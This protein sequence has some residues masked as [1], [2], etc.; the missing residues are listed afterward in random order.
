MQL[1]SDQLTESKPVYPLDLSSLRAAVQALA[2]AVD[3]VSSP[4]FSAVDLRWRDTLVAGVVQHFEST[5]ELCW[6]MLKR[7]LERELPSPTE[8][9]GSSYRDLFRLGHQRGLVTSVEPW[10]EFRELR[11]ITADT[12]ALDKAKKVASGAPALL[13]EAR[14]LLSIIEVRNRA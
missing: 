7:Q 4:E 13:V 9:D 6:K 12:Y 5:F 2:N 3:V 8:L 1:T 11:N 10:F 14:L